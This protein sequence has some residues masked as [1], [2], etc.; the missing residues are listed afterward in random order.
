L[1]PQQLANFDSKELEANEMTEPGSGVIDW[2]R[3]F[4]HADEAGI[5]HYFVE[6]DAPKDPFASLATSYKYL[7]TLRF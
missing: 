7:S 6:H 1:T 2:K 4:S 3:I 5:Q